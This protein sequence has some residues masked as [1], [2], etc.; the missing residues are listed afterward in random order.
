MKILV[1]GANGFIGSSLVQALTARGDQVTC[2]LFP[3]TQAPWLQHPQTRFLEA[4]LT[5]PLPPPLLDELA[6]TDQIYHLAG[7][8]IGLTP[9]HFFRVNSEGTRHL[10]E[11]CR[12]YAK[13]LQRFVLVSSATVC[14]SSPDGVQATEEMHAPKTPYAASK[15]E[16]ER[17]AREEFADLPITII[18]PTAIYGP[19][20]TEWVD[21][22]N[23][24]LRWKRYAVFGVWRKEPRMDMCH[25]DDLIRGMLLAAEHPDAIGQTFLLGGEAKTW[26]EIG[27]AAA[28]ALGIQ[29]KPLRLP[30]PLLFLVAATVHLISLIIRRPFELNIWRYTDFSQPNWVFSHEKAKRLLGYQPQI[31]FEEGAAQTARW[32]LEERWIKK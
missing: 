18:R 31:P 4:D 22:L 3:R 26:S 7:A 21:M 27:Q 8:R 2:V 12:Q 13:K 16:A 19:R 23:L 15:G 20:T 6:Q 28:K 9:K 10:L 30:L 11:N 1:T 25:V 29:A 17:I 5:Q 14:G 24:C 32:M